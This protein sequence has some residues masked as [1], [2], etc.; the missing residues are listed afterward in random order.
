MVGVA[1][2][3]LSLM[4]LG[5][6]LGP[7][8]PPVASAA[9]NQPAPVAPAAP[10]ATTA[11]APLAVGPADVKVEA[12]GWWS[13]SM[14]DERTGTVYGSKNMTETNTTASMVKS[15]IAAD[16]LRQ[17]AG[18]GETPE[19]DRLA[20]LTRMIR[21]SNNAVANTVY[22]ELGGTSSIQRLIDICGLTDS[23]LSEDG[24]WSRT[25]LSARD[26]ARMGSCLADGR[27]AGTQWTGWLLDE[28][29]QVRGSGDFGIRS[30]FP[31][32]VRETIAIKN[33]W[34]DRVAEDEYHLS[35]LAIG[36]DWTVG[37]LTRYPVDLGQEYGADI[38]EQVGAQLRA[39]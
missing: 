29:R 1:A 33:G 39:N 13:W 23:R 9:P 16:Y 26:T 20:D 36:T 3:L 34:I 30:A 8:S 21:D 19:A 27:A 31:T 11:P 17:A 25:L 6:G 38:C 28:M 12:T 18:R 15:W 35:C 32:G 24:G 2:G 10:T 14:I 5:L 37:V 22:A 7:E 4:L